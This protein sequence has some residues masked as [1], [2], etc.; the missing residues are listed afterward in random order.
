[1]HAE[2]SQLFYA[3]FLFFKLRFWLRGTGEFPLVTAQQEKQWL[4]LSA[5][6]AH[7]TLTL[8]LRQGQA[9]PPLGT[10]PAPEYWPLAPTGSS[11]PRAQ[12]GGAKGKSL[13]G[14]SFSVQIQH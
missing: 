6:S 2:P 4:S 13:C 3:D 5:G 1:M 11:S 12:S 8:E 7:W 14:N 10:G 9:L